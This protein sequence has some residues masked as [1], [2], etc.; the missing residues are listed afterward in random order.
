MPYGIASFVFIELRGAP[1]IDGSAEAGVG[2]K[3]AA[4]GMS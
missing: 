4:A 2:G 3:A 1:S